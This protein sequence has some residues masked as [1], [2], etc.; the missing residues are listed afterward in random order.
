MNTGRLSFLLLVALSGQPTRGDGPVFVRHDVNPKSTYSACAVMDV[1]KDG[2]L[3]IVAG[4]WWYEAPTWQKHFLRDVEIIRGRYDDYSNLP[5]DINGDGWPDLISANYRSRTLY[6]I[7][8]PGKKLGPWRTH[9]VAVP[10]PMET[11]RLVDIDGDGQLDVLP[12]G[13]QWAAWWEFR[14]KKG[15]RNQV[16]WLRHDLPKELAGH[17]VGAGDINGD[18]RIDLVGPTGWL[19]APLDRRGGRWLWHPEFF[20]HRDCSIPIL[21][22]DVD[23]D[24]DNDIVYGRGHRTGLYWLEQIRSGEKRTWQRHAIDT[25]WSQLHSLLRADIDNDGVAEVIAGKRYMGHDGRD[26][27]EYD[28]MYIYC[29]QFQ[30]RTRSWRRMLI[31]AGWH[32]GFGLDPKVADLDGDGDLDLVAPGRSGLFWFENR[33]ISKNERP[34]TP[35]KDIAPA[36]YPDHANLL[37]FRHDDGTLR[38]VTNHADWGRRRAH[39]LANMQLVMGSL[40]GPEIRVPLD[41]HVVKETKADGYT[42]R[43]I[44][45]A[46][47]PGVR[48]PAYLLIPDQAKDK[49]PAVLCLHQTTKVGK[50]EPAGLAGDS[51]LHFAHELARQGYIC[52]VPDYP[53]FGEFKYDFRTNRHA[54]GTMQAIW[55]NLR[56]LDVLE[57]VPQ[58]DPDR[59]ACIGHSLGGHNALFTA[60]FDLRIRAVIASCAFSTFSRDDLDSW[61]SPRYMPK[62]RETYKSDARKLPFDFHEVVGA[63]APRPVFI[64]A[65]VRDHDFAVAGVKQVAASLTPLYELLDARDKL[66]FVHPDSGHDFPAKV[67]QEAYQWLKHWLK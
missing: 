21:V 35:P 28:P 18:G 31:S 61:S 44:T 17:G 27:G 14:R 40:P 12:N 47:E 22:F 41:I 19:E 30:P 24:K 67:R 57:T 15:T 45:F 8:H 2:K 49:T 55:C 38:K 53:S 26:P 23:G 32:A 39:V 42:R 11:A 16:E 9:V 43:K 34:A 1:N 63:L 62:I 54:S 7:E 56:A 48:V 52:I 60:A 20:L 36:S 51:D 29:Y 13:T 50:D 33:L 65:P 4:G 64:N 5:I 25:S 37:V 58:V 3:D 10:G 46:A 66:R 59:I 6:W